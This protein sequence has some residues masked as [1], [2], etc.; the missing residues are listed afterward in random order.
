MPHTKIKLKKIFQSLTCI[1]LLVALLFSVSCASTKVSNSRSLPTDPAVLSGKLENGVSYFIQRN[2]EPA[3]RIMLRLVIQ[4]GSNMEEDDQQGVAHLLEHMAFNGSENFEPQEL[5]SYFES[6]GMNFG[7]DVNAY[8][9]F[10]ETVYMLEVPADDPTMLA[11][12]MLVFHDW[13]NGLTISQEELDK[14]RGVVVEEWRLRRGLSGRINDTQIPLLLKDSRY[15]ERLPIGK[16]DV[17]QN[18]PRQRVVD[19]YEKWYRPE[20]MSVVVVGDVEPE[21]IQSLIQDVMGD[22]PASEKPIQSET[23]SVPM[24]T[25]PVVQI[26]RDPEQPYQLI[27]ILEQVESHPITTVGDMKKSIITQIASSIFNMRLS[28]ISQTAD[29]PW[30]DAAIANQFIT[31]NTAF[32]LLGLVPLN[33]QFDKGFNTLLEEFLRY[34]KFGAIPEE[35]D[36]AKQNILASAEQSWKNRDKI[37]SSQLASDIVN[38]IVT[39]DTLISTEEF[40]KVYQEIVPTITLQE[41]NEV[42]ANWFKNLG[43]ILFALIPEN[44]TN[45][46]N[47][48]ELLAMWQNFKPTKPLEPYTEGTVEGDLMALPSE[49]GSVSYE[50]TLPG[51]D[52]Q[53]YK[54]SNG[55]TLLLNQTDFKHNEILFNAVSNGGLSLLSDKE[56]PSGA[57]AVSYNDLSGLNGFT[58]TD[59][60]KKLA[61]KNVSLY[62]YI[63]DYNEQLSGSSTTQ[64]LETLM[65]L[66]HLQFTAADFTDTAWANLMNSATLQAQSHGS[67]P[68]DVFSDKIIQLLYG[69]NIRKQA[70][71][72]Q[73]LEKVNA[74]TAAQVFIQRFADAGDFTFTF[75]GD[76]DQEKILELAA[77]YLATLPSTNSQENAIWREPDFPKGIH[78]AVVK[79][80]L[81]EQSQVFIAFGGS[82]PT[83]DA[84]TAYQDEE[85]LSMLQNLLDI[86][87]REVV[88]E[89][90]GGSYHV[91]VSASMELYP[92][93]S[94]MVEILFGCQPGREQELT[95]AVINEVENLRKNLVDQSYLTKLQE[96]YRRSKETAL[97][98]NSYWVTMAGR[99][100]LH[101]FPTTIIA[102]TDT[103]PNMVTPQ[104]M[105]Q[106]AQRYLDP[107]NYVLVFL[108][109][110]SA[111]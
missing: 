71:T 75:T 101:D 68:D 25:K 93:R 87:L 62:T 28:E 95:D 11:T 58:P 80:G 32:H 34:K 102:D 43:T 55:A 47:Q 33:N 98:T 107:N 85:M 31:H 100:A 19:F 72:T 110:E 52:I 4:A 91:N 56:Y 23:Y 13:A 106:L 109:P 24:Q 53:S 41:I 60:Q 74:Q 90:K 27:Q 94:F 7:A 70:L 8:T 12:G 69:D 92:Q 103:I 48:E 3:N 57:F 81:E 10:E 79:K 2:T 104:A 37:N 88:R 17:I 61:G 16:M 65:Q 51:T 67:Q 22:I 45:F 18:V 30:I 105:R 9:S 86:R 78:K 20:L 63:G 83:V 97:K 54:M 36:R 14:E 49:Q 21:K 89:E 82:L 44:S 26:M 99:S 108:E 66:I 29:S 73:L 77:T 42:A 35:L 6:I 39:G 111:Q 64:D 76:F 5:V 1:A 40:Y 84:A 38:S 59:L 96:S 50:G 15:A 46:P